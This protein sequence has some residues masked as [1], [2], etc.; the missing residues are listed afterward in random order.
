[1]NF[2]LAELEAGDVDKAGWPILL[3][4]RGNLSE[5]VGYNL[6]MVTDG[7]IR[8]PGDRSVLQGVSRG[9]VFDLAKRLGIP[10]VEEDLQPYDLYTAN[11]AFLTSTSPCVLPVTR[12]DRRPIGR[13]APGPIVERLLAAWSAEVGVDIVEQAVKFGPKERLESKAGS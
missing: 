4:S 5:G 6:F 13:G 3:D 11:E 10:C 12:V 7:A 1:M 8:T 9:V 2:N